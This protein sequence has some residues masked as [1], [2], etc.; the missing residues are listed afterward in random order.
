[1]SD[2]EE[3]MILNFRRKKEAGHTLLVIMM[4][5]GI[6]T[7]A[8]GTYLELTSTQNQSVVRSLC[9]NSA[10]PLAEAGIEEALSHIS[11]NIYNYANDGWTQNGSNYFKLRQ[12]GESYFTVSIAG[13][14]GSLVTITSTGYSHW[15]DTNYLSRN[16]IVTAQTIPSMTFPGMIATN[17]AIGG[18]FMADSYDSST[19][20]GSTGG[21]YDSAKRGAKAFIATPSPG[22]TVSGSSHIYGNVAAGPGGSVSAKGAAIVGDE[23]Y[24]NKGIQPGHV[25]NNFVA[26]IPDVVPPY[27][28]ANAPDKGKVNGVNFDYVLSGGK[29]M[30]SDL[31]GGSTTTMVV[32]SDSVLYVTGDVNLDQIVF[33]NGAKLELYAGGDTINMNAAITGAKPTQF[34]VFGLPTCTSMNMTGGENFVGIIYAPECDLKASGH[35][36]LSGAITTHGIKAT[37]SFDFHYDLDAGRAVVLTPVTIISWAEPY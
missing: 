21:Q 5:G 18:N 17:L 37:G 31:K 23:N 7:L 20:T 29:Y 4:I 34:K 11:K 12:L 26:S 3:E 15:R 16:L 33:L 8:L 14:P 19:N 36:S 24:Y 25:T 13:A 22:F 35:A 28:S 9:W 6:L 10:L 30:T 32:E 2:G 27:Q 1:M